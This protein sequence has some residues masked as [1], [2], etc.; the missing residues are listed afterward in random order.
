MPKLEKIFGWNVFVVMN[1]NFIFQIGL[2][3]GFGGMI[4]LIARGI[5]RI[6]DRLEE[7]KE[8][9][10]LVHWFSKIPLEKLDASLTIFWEKILR[11]LRVCLLK[12]DNCLVSHLRKIKSA[13]QSNNKKPDLLQ[14]VAS[15]NAE[16]NYLETEEK[17]AE[18]NVVD[19]AENS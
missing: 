10:Q 12:M 5:P 18:S 19:N 7:E 2:M 1:Y 4:Y 8:K 9:K 15:K 3:V 16:E 11:R 6:D 17:K 13:N 14:A